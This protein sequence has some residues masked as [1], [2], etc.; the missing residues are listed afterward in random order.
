MPTRLVGNFYK[1]ENIF[2]KISSKRVLCAAMSACLTFS[3]L[4]GSGIYSLAAESE[5]SLEK[6]VL[7][8]SDTKE[9]KSE[10]ISKTNSEEKSEKHSEEQSETKSEYKTEKTAVEE[11]DTKD[12]T[13][14]EATESTEDEVTQIS[15]EAGGFDSSSPI[16]PIV[17]IVL[18]LAV[19]AGFIIKKR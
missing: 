8:A 10:E 12:V 19:V 13:E 14:E 2:M 16:I 9:E 11:T 17:L 4:F 15:E 7:E 3:G 5:Q 18:G 1:G 6:E